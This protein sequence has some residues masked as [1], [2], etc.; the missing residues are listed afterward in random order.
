MLNRLNKGR[1]SQANTNHVE[2]KASG[3]EE[4]AKVYLH[5]PV[6]CVRGA[7]KIQVVKHSSGL[8]HKYWFVRD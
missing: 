6:N 4:K 2:E 5:N 8:F 1:L 3:S 7:K